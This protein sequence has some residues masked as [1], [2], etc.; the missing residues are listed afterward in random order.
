MRDFRK[1]IKKV[2]ILTNLNRLQKLKF[3]ISDIG[4]SILFCPDCVFQFYAG[5]AAKS[6]CP[7][8]GQR[9]HVVTITQELFELVSNQPPS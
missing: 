8:C 2:Y 5:V 6:V 7:D 4:K 9:M 3:E 1:D